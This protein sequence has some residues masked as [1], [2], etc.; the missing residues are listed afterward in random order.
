MVGL[1]RIQFN[2]LGTTYT[3]WVNQNEY[4]LILTE[5]EKAEKHGWSFPEESQEKQ[6]L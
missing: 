3:A 1:R 6:P 4:D 5:R 2:Y